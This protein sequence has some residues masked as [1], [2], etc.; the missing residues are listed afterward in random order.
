MK[1]R[2]KI[3]LLF[4]ICLVLVAGLYLAYEISD[5]RTR[6]EQYAVYSA[7]LNQGLL[8]NYHDFGDGHGILVIL[9]HTARPRCCGTNVLPGVSSE[10]RW[11]LF[12]RSL[13][14]IHFERKFIL[15]T[16]YK[17]VS[18]DKLVAGTLDLA[19]LSPEE[20]KRTIGGYITFTRIS[21]DHTRTLALFYTEHLA[22]G[23]CGG[24]N[25]VLMQKQGGQWR[26]ID[27]YSPWVS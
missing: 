3:V 1:L 13:T 17:F 8:E 19:E 27:E 5:I 14:S 20:R 9:D 25:L 18:S 11:N 23:L 7:Y 15:P 2:Q 4:V 24:G 26:V 21:F 22:C 6:S 12:L 10:M 16:E